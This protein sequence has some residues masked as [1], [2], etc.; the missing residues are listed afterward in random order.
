[1]L[2]V[3]DGCQSG[4]CPSGPTASWHPPACPSVHPGVVGLATGEWR[5][6]GHLVAFPGVMLSHSRCRDAVPMTPRSGVRESVCP[7][8]L[9]IVRD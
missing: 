1:M 5:R 4:H 9:K 8:A 6:W 2:G 3:M 7:A